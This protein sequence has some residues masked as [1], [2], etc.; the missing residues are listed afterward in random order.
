MDEDLKDKLVFI[1]QVKLLSKQAPPMIWLT[2]L[3]TLTISVVLLLGN[4]ALWIPLSLF[5][6]MLLLNA[7]RLWHHRIVK[8]QKVTVENVDRHAAFFV[9]FSFI[10]G[11]IWGVLGLIAPIQSDIFLLVMIATLFC[12]L[13][14]GGVSY[15]S[16][17][18]LAF[19]TYAIP[20][21]VPFSIRC[22]ISQEDMLVAVGILMLLFL[23]VNLINS[24]LTQA[25]VLKQISLRQ[26]N[27]DLIKRLRHEKNSAEEA[28]QIADQNNQAKSR[29]L[30]AASHDLRQPLHAMGFFLEALQHEKDPAKIQTLITRVAQSTESLRNLI[31]SLLDMSRIEA[32]VMEPRRS[33]FI[34]NEL[35]ADIIGEFANQAE[36]K[37]LDLTLTPCGQ[38]VYTDKDMLGRILRNLVSNALHYTEHGFV[39]ISCDI[40]S[41]FVTILVSDSGIGIG[42]SDKTEIFQEFF[43]IAHQASGQKSNIMRGTSR[44]LGLG[45]SIVDGLCRLL[46]HDLK[47]HS[48]LGVGSVFSIKIPQG[49]LK[50]LAPKVTE[51]NPMPGD[52]SAKI[53]LLDS[54]GKS[55]KIIS[56][57][58]RQW[59]YMVADFEAMDAAIDFL[60]SEDFIPDLIISDMT[61]K[62]AAGRDAIE[63][64][65]TKITQKI[66]AIILTDN[67]GIRGEA[68]DNIR[69]E[70][71]SHLQKPVQPAKL[72]SMV[73]YLLR[74]ET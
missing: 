13:I 35:L 27:K 9:C 29:Y 24:Y 3:I 50:K 15:L 68:K 21:V 60:E 1:E 72:R 2:L 17:Y 42:Q 10:G 65:Q 26:K 52:V 5:A 22:L 62:N 71:L 61:L 64:I 57:M 59:G 63:Y 30:A 18:R 38:T 47:L 46:E 37:G 36:E 14:T 11:S 6:S 33:H 45:L 16:T 39:N 43:Q 70:G 53:V 44:G 8:Y 40:G 74:G 23:G 25:G 34:L 41:G 51:L 4:V 58:M 67:V 69:R 7:A 20:C 28:R 19:F 54:L 12:G 73:S 55:R 66:P 32:G 48:E 56:E 49:N 31:G